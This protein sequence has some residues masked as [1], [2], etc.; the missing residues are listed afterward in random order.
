LLRFSRRRTSASLEEPQ[1]HSAH[2]GGLD[3]AA[4]NIGATL[5][6]RE[7]RVPELLL[8]NAAGRAA[9]ARDRA[10]GTSEALRVIS[11][12]L[13]SLQSRLHQYASHQRDGRSPVPS[14]NSG[15][16]PIRSRASSLAPQLSPDAGCE[17]EALAKLWLDTRL[18][19]SS[20]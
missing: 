3:R 20:V 18:L 14:R 7:R 2:V 6:H 8:D 11:G 4:L 16:A 9:A 15:E 10:V 19:T 13:P 12:T 17:L 1:L 5:R